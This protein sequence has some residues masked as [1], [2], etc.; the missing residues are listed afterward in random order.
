[1]ESRGLQPMAV[2]ESR[3]GSI[4]EYGE[5][6]ASQVLHFNPRPSAIIAGNDEIA[7]G[8]WRSFRKLG[9]S[10]PDDMSL[11]GFDDR[12]EALLMDPHLTTVRVNSDGIGQSLMKLLLEKLHEP[13]AHLTKKIIPTEMIIRDTVKRFSPG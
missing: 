13:G 4:S 10:V 9:V 2:T 6:A 8:L 3:P 5:W 1:M 11:V 7:H 12:E